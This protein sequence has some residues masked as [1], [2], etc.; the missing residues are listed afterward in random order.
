M[1]GDAE[2]LAFNCVFGELRIAGHPLC[3]LDDIQTTEPGNRRDVSSPADDTQ[4]ALWAEGSF[5]DCRQCRSQPIESAA[6]PLQV[7]G[8]G[9]RHDVEILGAAYEPVRPYGD[10]ANHDEVDAGF[11]QGIE[12]RAEVE[13]P[14]R[15]FAA[16]LIA[17]SCL[18]SE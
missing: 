16:P 12:Q 5:A 7:V 13:F 1:N 8:I 10:A 3:T 4:V 14:Q 6:Q 15:T 9:I 2:Q 11:M 17:L 18:H